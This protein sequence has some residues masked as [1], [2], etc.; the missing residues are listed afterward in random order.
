MGPCSAAPAA[1][2]I[3]D[4]DAE[5]P[6]PTG[7]EPCELDWDNCLDSSNPEARRASLYAGLHTVAVLGPRP[8]NNYYIVPVSRRSGMILAL[9]SRPSR[10]IAICF[11]TASAANTRLRST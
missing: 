3:R 9:T 4:Y 11:A 6:K 10:H 8:T 5:T 1:V 7:G 2:D